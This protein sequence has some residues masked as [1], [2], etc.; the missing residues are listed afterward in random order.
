MLIRYTLFLGFS[1]LGMT[2]FLNAAD[3]SGS[4]LQ[5]HIPTHL[6]EHVNVYPNPAIDKLTIDLSTV[7]YPE[8]EVTVF[9]IIQSPITTFKMSGATSMEMDLSGYHPGVYYIRFKYLQD[10]FVKKIVKE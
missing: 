5:H 6:L 9:N 2:M 7:D 10:V 3:N 1:L 8:V 4:E